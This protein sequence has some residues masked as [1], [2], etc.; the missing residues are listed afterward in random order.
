VSKN[1]VEFAKFYQQ[2]CCHTSLS[3]LDNQLETYIIDMHTISVFERNWRSF[4]NVVE[5]RK[6]IV[7]P[8]VYWPLKLAMILL[9]DDD[10]TYSFS[11]IFSTPLA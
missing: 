10:H 1:L 4:K 7:Y 5:T 2:E 8:L 3:V 11:L 6:H 9:V